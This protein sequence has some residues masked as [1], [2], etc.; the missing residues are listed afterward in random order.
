MGLKVLGRVTSINV[1]KVL[2]AADEMGL[3]YERE[4]WGKPARDPNVPEF[5]KLN[6]NAQVPVIVDDGFVLWESQAIIRYLA[7]KNGSDLLPSDARER[8]IVDQ[9]LGWQ[10]TELNP[11]WMYA[12]K[13]KIRN[14]PAN[15]DPAL[16]VES[17]KGWADKLRIFEARLM[18]EGAFVANGRFSLA[19]IVLGLSTHRWMMMPL[20]RPRFPAVEGHYR[21]LLGRIAAKGYMGEGT[22]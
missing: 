11:T 9:W 6:P 21:A 5:L 10:A 22:P 1:R 12:Y 4:D 8:A 19:D 3:S 16:V 17:M 2:W 18:G 7:E 13:A 14:T 20:E 15:P